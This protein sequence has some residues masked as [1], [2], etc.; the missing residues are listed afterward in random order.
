MF[1]TSHEEQKKTTTMVQDHW[2]EQE[3]VFT[4]E[5]STLLGKHYAF[6]ILLLRFS[7]RAM[8]YGK[9]HPEEERGKRQFLSYLSNYKKMFD[10][11]HA[12]FI[13]RKECAAMMLKIIK[14]K[15]FHQISFGL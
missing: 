6:V 4:N 1:W 12:D 15:S 8:E 11:Y 10:V 14:D 9:Y 2:I 13:M 3:M 7:R 5:A